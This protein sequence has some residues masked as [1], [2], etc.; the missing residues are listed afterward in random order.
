MTRR[1]GVF[2]LAMMALA[3]G[4]AADTAWKWSGSFSDR[5]V[6]LLIIGDIQVHSRRADPTSARLVRLSIRWLR[7]QQTEDAGFFGPSMV[8]T[9]AK[10][11]RVAARTVNVIHSR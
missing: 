1:L 5:T 8:S 7:H 6:S 4:L 11:S 9:S 3:V 2:S 10:R